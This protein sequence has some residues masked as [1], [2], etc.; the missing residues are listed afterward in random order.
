MIDGST[1]FSGVATA[2]D[3]IERRQRSEFQCRSSHIVTSIAPPWMLCF[4]LTIEI[5]VFW[6]LFAAKIKDTLYVAIKVIHTL[7]FIVLSVFLSPIYHFCCWNSE[8]DN[9]LK[10]KPELV[11]SLLTLALNDAITYDKVWSL[12]GF[13]SLAFGSLCWFRELVQ[14]VCRPQKLEVQMGLS[15]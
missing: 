14:F 11:P 9:L 4:I 6:L 13:I 2:A 15:G 10:A 3:L 7:H 8:P 5:E 12:N 1:R